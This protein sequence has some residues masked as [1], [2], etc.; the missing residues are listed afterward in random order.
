VL[1][2]RLRRSGRSVVPCSLTDAGDAPLLDHRET[3]MTRSSEAR[4]AAS[5]VAALGLLAASSPPPRVPSSTDSA[6]FV[7]RRSVVF[8]GHAMGTYVHVAIVTTDSATAAPLA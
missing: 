3:G 7:A 1:G 4:I 2:S 5:L 6:S 8:P